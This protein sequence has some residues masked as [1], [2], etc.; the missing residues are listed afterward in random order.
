MT[1][2][3]ARATCVFGAC[4]VLSQIGCGVATTDSTLALVNVSGTWSYV[5]S[6]S[7]QSVASSGA[8][9]LSQDRTV[10]FSG[11]FDA[12]EQDA[13]GQIQRI[14]GVV[15]GRTIDETAVDFDVVIDPTLTRHHAGAVHGDSLTG[16]WVELSDR[17]VA[18]SGSFR[19]RRR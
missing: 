4:L 2:L 7:G 15:S 8:L 5:G 9:V 11:T 10:Q 6:R 1:R 13:S 17:G 18:A 19:A 3:A 16:T 12:S 14:V